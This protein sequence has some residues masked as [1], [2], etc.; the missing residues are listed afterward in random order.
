MDICLAPAHTMA[1]LAQGQ[2]SSDL[3][4]VLLGLG[5]QSGASSI[6]ALALPVAHVLLGFLGPL[7]MCIMDKPP[8]V[9]R[10][11]FFSAVAQRHSHDPHVS[12]DQAADIQQHSHSES[13]VRQLM[14]N[15]TAIVMSIL[16]GCHHA[17]LSGG[18]LLLLLAP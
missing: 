4:L 2:S 9:V 3:L 7:I 16:R 8:A 6:L 1:S 13:P 5:S 12:H 18:P 15:A 11:P 17:L 14:N 10:L